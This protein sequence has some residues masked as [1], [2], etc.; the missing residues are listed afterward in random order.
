MGGLNPFF[1][2]ACYLA[3]CFS[4][5]PTQ[6]QPNVK[7][8]ALWSKIYLFARRYLFADFRT[9]PFCIEVTRP[10][11]LQAAIILA[12]FLAARGMGGRPVTL[13]GETYGRVLGGCVLSKWGTPVGP[14]DLSG[15]SEPLNPGLSPPNLEP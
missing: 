1:L 12:E 4:T 15:T 5:D 10:R 6:R 7:K 3:S 14:Y 11:P 13:V 9:V 8:V 2:V